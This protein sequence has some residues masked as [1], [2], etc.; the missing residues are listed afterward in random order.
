MPTN[1]G[2]IAPAVSRRDY[3]KGQPNKEN[4]IAYCRYYKHLGAMSKAMVRK[5]ECIQKNCKY[6]EKNLYN[7]YWYER[8]AYI[9]K[10]KREKQLRKINEWKDQ[11]GTKKITGNLLTVNSSD[12]NT[13]MSTM[14][15]FFYSLEVFHVYVFYKERLMRTR[16]LGGF[17][18]IDKAMQKTKES[19][20]DANGEY[21]V[22]VSEKSESVGYRVLEKNRNLV[23]VDL[24]WGQLYPALRRLAE[25]N[26]FV[27]ARKEA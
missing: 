2:A 17:Y 21:V 9:A 18:G 15:E 4:T 6:Y 5:H 25:E 1:W 20:R 12:I 24:T 3:M 14:L 8:K 23:E 26:Y 19:I 13:D 10:K 27:D 22:V 7:P 11:R 16:H